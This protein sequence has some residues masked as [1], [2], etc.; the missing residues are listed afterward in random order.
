MAYKILVA[1]PIY[2]GKIRDKRKGIDFLH[3]P[4]IFLTFA[5]ELDNN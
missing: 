5:P 4:K 3:S 2:S 1:I